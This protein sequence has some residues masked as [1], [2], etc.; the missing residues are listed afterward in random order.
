MVGAALAAAFPSRA[1]AADG[2]PLVLVTADLEAGVLAVDAVSGRVRKRIGTLDGPRSI[3]AAGSFAVVGHSERGAVSLIDTR[4]LAVVRVLGGFREPR[5]TA[6]HPDGRHAYVTDAGRGE[7]AVL[8]LVRGRVVARLAVGARARHVTIDPRGRRLWV[9]LGST[10]EEIAVLGV[11]APDRLRLLHRF[12]PPFR[13][14]DVGFAPD[15]RHV[16]VSSG[17]RFELAV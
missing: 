4:R 11:D 5:Y 3:E 12:S 8:D 16:W 13:A 9:A 17:D 10:A 15:G 7:V 1:L 14:H 6:A 2:E